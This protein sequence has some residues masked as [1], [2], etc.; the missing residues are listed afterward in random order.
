MSHKNSEYK[1][2]FANL[3]DEYATLTLQVNKYVNNLSTLEDDNNTL[4]T[5]TANL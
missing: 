3:R 4:H 2:L 1:V 5:T